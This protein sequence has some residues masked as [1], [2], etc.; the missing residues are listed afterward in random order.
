MEE[1]WKPIKGYEGYYEVSNMG[2]VKSLSRL[3]YSGHYHTNVQRTEERIKKIAVSSNGYANTCLDKNGH[4]KTKSIHSLVW[5]AFGDKECPKD[6]QIDHIN[7]IK[8]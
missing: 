7:G 2:R 3:F 4:S 1:I 8:T 6:L 5:N